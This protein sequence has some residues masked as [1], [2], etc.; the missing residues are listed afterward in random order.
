MKRVA[1]LDG[2]LIVA[3]MLGKDGQGQLGRLVA[4]VGPLEPPRREPFEIIVFI[5]GP[6]IDEHFDAVDGARALVGPHPCPAPSSLGNPN[7]MFWACKATLA[8]PIA[9]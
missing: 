1:A 7:I 4:L 8:L 5:K 9:A 2:P 6:I 3:Q